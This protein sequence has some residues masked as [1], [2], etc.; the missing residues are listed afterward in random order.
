MRLLKTLYIHLYQTATAPH[1][2]LLVKTIANCREHVGRHQ[3]LC[4]SYNAITELGTEILCH[5]FHAIVSK[6]G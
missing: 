4:H 1:N 2:K 5:D 3:V 6:H